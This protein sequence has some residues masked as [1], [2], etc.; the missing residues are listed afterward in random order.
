MLASARRLGIRRGLA[1]R[2]EAGHGQP[3]RTCFLIFSILRRRRA[4]AWVPFQTCL[5]VVVCQNDE[6]ELY[7]SSVPVSHV[8]RQSFGYGDHFPPNAPGVGG[9]P[10]TCL[11]TLQACWCSMKQSCIC[12]LCSKES[13]SCTL[14]RPC[15][16]PLS[17][18]PYFGCT[19]RLR[20][21]E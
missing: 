12:A 17:T 21:A 13:T 7:Q 19:F 10:M 2:A 4:S 15:K 5:Q 14:Q 20:L 18:F 16:A 6:N 11:T 8:R 1:L 3:M 9:A